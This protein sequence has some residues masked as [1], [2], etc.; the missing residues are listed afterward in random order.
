MELT[1]K[2]LLQDALNTEKYLICMYDQFTKESSCVPLLELLMDNNSEILHTLHDIF[3]EMKN[4]QF[5]PVKPAETK[6]INE[7]ITM[8]EETKVCYKEDF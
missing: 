6:M 3:I 7:A 2:E 8:L 1:L 5:Y 4:R